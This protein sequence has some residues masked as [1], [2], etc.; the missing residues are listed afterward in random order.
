[1]AAY[2]QYFY[3]KKE[4]LKWLHILPQ[5][6][7]PARAAWYVPV[8]ARYCKKEVLKWLHILP[9]RILPARAAWYVPV[10][11]RVMSI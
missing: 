9:Q 2:L 6:I 10:A 3:C 4:V 11:A 1:L 7:L 5:R 8:A